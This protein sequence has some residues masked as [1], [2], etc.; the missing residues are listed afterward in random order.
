M[1]ILTRYHFCQVVVFVMCVVGVCDAATSRNELI[2]FYFHEGFPYNMIFCFLHFVHGARLSVHQLKRIP[3]TLRSKRRNAVDLTL[4]SSRRLIQVHSNV[5]AEYQN[6]TTIWFALI[7]WHCIISVKAEIN[8]GSIE[9]LGYEALWDWL[10]WKL[11][12]LSVTRHACVSLSLCVC[13]CVFFLVYSVCGNA[14][15][16]IST[17]WLSDWASGCTVLNLYHMVTQ[18]HISV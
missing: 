1:A 5:Q 11:S 14:L 8:S 4:M 2:N 7:L 13:V 9:L 15:I 18:S 16:F 10:C 17:L 6:W 12:G 3:R